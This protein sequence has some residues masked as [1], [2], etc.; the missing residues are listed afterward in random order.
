MVR[1]DPDKV[2]PLRDEAA[3]KTYLASPAKRG[4]DNN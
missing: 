1:I 2:V 4:G 3:S